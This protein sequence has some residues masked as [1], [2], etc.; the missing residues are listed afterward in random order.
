M[1]GSAGSESHARGQFTGGIC[2]TCGCELPARSKPGRPRLYCDPWCGEVERA[3][4]VLEAWITEHAAT[5]A[6]QAVTNHRSRLLYLA[7]LFN[8]RGPY[9]RRERQG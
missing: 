1:P 2:P 6:E 8:A 5:L 3:Y 9:P 7:N 4:Q